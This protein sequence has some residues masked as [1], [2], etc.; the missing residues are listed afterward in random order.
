MR[1]FMK[2]VEAR[3]VDGFVSGPS[4]TELVDLVNNKG[5][6]R[7]VAHEGS[8]YLAPAFDDIHF[9]MRSSLGITPYWYDEETDIYPVDYG[10]DFYVGNLSSV[11]AGEKVVDDGGRQDWAFGEEPMWNID[12]VGVWCNAE[13]AVAL[14]NRQFS[15]MVGTTSP[16]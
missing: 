11:Q 9:G 8:V 6:M 2:I 12:G 3:M 10:F 5:D 15:R 7:G 16:K 4:S 1:E 13:K 14:Q